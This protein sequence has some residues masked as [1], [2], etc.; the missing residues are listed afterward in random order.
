MTIRI[1]L[2][3]D[4]PIVLD[5]LEQLFLLEGDFTVVARCRDGE[6]TLA[7]LR[8]LRPDVLVLDVRM[9]RGDGIE[10]LATIQREELPTRVLVLTAAVDDEQV[11]ALLRHGAHGLVLKETAPDRL[12]AAVRHV[13]AGGQELDPALV[14]RA[15]ENLVRR[16]R[17]VR[18][19]ARLLTPREREIVRMV[20]SGMRN[21][22]LADQLG[23]SEGTV[24]IHLHRIYEKLQVAG[25]LELV[26]FAQKHHLD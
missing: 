26:L 16:D 9:P 20:S 6:T 23:I 24:K 1:A 21:R 2:A 3:D 8:E 19:V 11:V 18:E 12:V 10:V 22:A 14:T 13:H 15:V 5:G 17:A 7:A 25:R 4:H